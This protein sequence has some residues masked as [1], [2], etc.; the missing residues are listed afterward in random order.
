[1]S[2]KLRVQMREEILKL[3][4]RVQK[5]MIYVTHDQIEAMTLAD[6]IVVMHEGR[7]EQVGSPLT[8]FDRPQTVFVA[9]FIGS[10]EMNLLD[11][12]YQDGAVQFGANR[13][14]LPGALPLPANAAL[15]VGI[16]PEHLQLGESQTSDGSRISL[17]VEVV[18]QLGTTTLVVGHS[19][20]Q[21][22]QALG[23]RFDA[24]PGERV[25]LTVAGE[26]LHFFDA[27]SGKRL[28]GAWEPSGS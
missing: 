24:K 20:G 8:I 15:K 4:R 3:H 26:R 18:E 22:L 25:A 13:V 9:G 21:R 14:A 12:Y 16:R 10:P 27:G 6:Q 28:S 11:M 1:M 23:P 5:P 19:D 17:Q 2:S 7:I